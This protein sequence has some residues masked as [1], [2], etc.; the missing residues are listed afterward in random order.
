MARADLS[1]GG[2]CYKCHHDI[3]SHHSGCTCI[4]Y[5]DDLMAASDMRV[6]GN[7]IN[8]GHAVNA[9]PRRPSDRNSKY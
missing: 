3:A 5:N 2:S 9:H 8:C 1:P 6:N 4:N 7:C